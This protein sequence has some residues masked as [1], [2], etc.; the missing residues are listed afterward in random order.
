MTWPKSYF[1]FFNFKLATTNFGNG[2]TCDSEKLEHYFMGGL[3]IEE[4]TAELEIILNIMQLLVK[5]NTLK[6][7]SE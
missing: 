3:T 5:N 1:Y 7:G 2:I 4:Q 6:G